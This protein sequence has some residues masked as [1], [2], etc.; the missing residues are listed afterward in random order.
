MTYIDANTSPGIRSLRED[1]GSGRFDGRV[2]SHP[3][4]LPQPRISRRGWPI[5]AGC[6]ASICR[7]TWRSTAFPVS[8]PN[9]PGGPPPTTTAP[10]K[11]ASIS[12]ATITATGT[13]KKFLRGFRLMFHSGCGVGPGV[14]ASLPG[15]GSSYKKRIKE[16]Y[17][18]NV[19]IG[20]MGEGLAFPWNYV[21][22]DPD[23]LTG[24]LRH[25]SGAL[26]HHRG[27]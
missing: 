21:E 1:G 26:P 15:F 25:P 24:S 6:W 10:A 17:P 16:L 14:G 27:V 8:C 3:V 9:L 22:I 7:S 4:Q 20:G 19:S 5:P 11:P 12:P 23:G 2:P 18:A 13:K